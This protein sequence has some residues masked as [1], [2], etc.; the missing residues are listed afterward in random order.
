MFHR[1][2]MT[3]RRSAICDGKP[4]NR[5]AL[6]KGDHVEGGYCGVANLPKALRHSFGV[7]TFQSNVP[8]T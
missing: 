8:R 5:L 1:H 7:K 6:R 4:H 2:R 3:S